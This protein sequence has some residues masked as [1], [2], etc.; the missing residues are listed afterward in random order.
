MIRL[1]TTLMVNSLTS[2]ATGIVLI[3]FSKSVAT[4]F[5]VTQALPFTGAGIFLVSFGTF[6]FLTGLKKPLDTKLVHFIILLDSLWIVASIITVLF[7]FSVLT[8]IG[9]LLILLVAGWVGLMVYLQNSGLKQLK[10]IQV[11]TLILALI[12]TLPAVSPTSAQS[13][14]P[15]KQELKA[16]TEPLRVV[17]A[18]LEAVKE[19]SHAKAAPLLDSLVQ[20]EQ[21]GSN[22]FSGY[23]KNAKEVFQM[24]RGFLDVTANSLILAEVKVLAVNGNQVACL[25]HW[26]AAQPIGKVL[27]VENIDVYTVENGKITKAVI[28]SANLKAEDDFWN[29]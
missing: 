26:K 24:F 6:V 13:N 28:Y 10:S 27:D 4:L 18:F 29:K 11:K 23:K 17:H 1:K 2:L 20:W 15:A 25:L 22:R 19:K 16:E 9:N 3:A 21:P 12:L 8:F 14:Y 7:L 5:G